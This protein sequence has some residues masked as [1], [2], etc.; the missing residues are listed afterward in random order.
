VAPAGTPN[1]YEN[2]SP[3]KQEKIPKR[4]ERKYI[5]ERLCVRILAAEGG[6][7]KRLKINIPPIVFKLRQITKPERKRRLKKINFSGIPEA[8]ATSLL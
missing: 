7:I 1:I 3:V 4:I 6:F 8:V 2:K 5:L